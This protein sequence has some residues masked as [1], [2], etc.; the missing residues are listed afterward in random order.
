MH[1]VCRT[2]TEIDNAI[3]ALNHLQAVAQDSKD[4][5]LFDSTMGARDLLS[6][7]LGGE[8]TSIGHLLAARV[9]TAARPA[10]EPALN[11]VERV[12]RAAVA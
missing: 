6:W 4:Q 7:L 9:Q 5:R 8:E 1:Q 10:M 12:T 2:P 11:L 3:S